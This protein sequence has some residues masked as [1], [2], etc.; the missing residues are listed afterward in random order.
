MRQVTKSKNYK[1]ANS[2]GFFLF[3]T[4]FFCI[5]LNIVAASTSGKNG[6]NRSKPFSLIVLTDPQFGMFASNAGFEKE[7]AL[8]EIAVAKINRL[9]PDFVIITGDFVNDQHSESQICEF[10]RITANLKSSIPVYYSP[11]NHDI[12]QVPDEVSLKKFERNYGSDRFTFRHKGSQFIGFNS[13]VIKAKLEEQEQKQFNWLSKE[14]KGC[15][16][17][18][19]I[20]LFTHYPFFNKTIDE[21]TAYSN[22]DKEYRK[23]YLDLFAKYKVT[24][25]FSGHHHNNGLST[26]RNIQFVTSSALGKPL[27]K[28]PS[29]MRIVK[30]YGER[31]EHEYYSLEELP[32]SIQFQ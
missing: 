2:K 15:K 29:G 30:V 26:Y 27:G 32:E 20:F 10:K 3:V 11:G 6:D 8:Y 22:I 18:Q 9:N 23:K 19:H 13:V 4:F 1:S 7:T 12:G 24:A 31:I 28:A 14:L 5:F 17:A 21:P 16:N 25:I